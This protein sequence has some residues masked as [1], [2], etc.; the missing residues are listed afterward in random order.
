MQF[1]FCTAE[2]CGGLVGRPGLDCVGSYNG[3]ATAGGFACGSVAGPIAVCMDTQ[4]SVLALPLG[5]VD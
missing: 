2:G 5:R 1:G 4:L 3:N